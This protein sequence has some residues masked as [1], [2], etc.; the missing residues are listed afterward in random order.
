MTFAALILRLLA[1]ARVPVFSSVGRSET[2]ERS[3][4]GVA[5]GVGV[6]ERWSLRQW[7]EAPGWRPNRS[8]WMQKGR[9]CWLL[10]LLRPLL[11][12]S[13]FAWSSLFVVWWSVRSGAAVEIS[14]PKVGDRR[15]KMGTMLAMSCLVDMMSSSRPIH[16]SRLWREALMLLQVVG[17]V[18]SLRPVGVALNMIQA[19]RA[20]VQ[21]MS[22]CCCWR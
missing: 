3:E 22:R 6:R 1:G 8:P 17:R 5:V 14:S 15:L 11:T 16:V 9:V 18:I 7:Y 4:C 10:L 21:M 12:T 19:L 20:K 2:R 13:I